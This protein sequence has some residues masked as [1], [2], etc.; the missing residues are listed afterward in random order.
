[1]VSLLMTHYTLFFVPFICFYIFLRS[2]FGRAGFRVGLRNAILWIVPYVVFSL[3]VVFSS[4]VRPSFYAERG[5]RAKPVSF[6]GFVLSEKDIF[7]E[8]F[9]QLSVMTVPNRVVDQFV[10][11]GKTKL[12][13]IK[14]LWWVSIG[15]ELLALLFLMVRRNRFLSVAMACLFSVIVLLVLN[16][17]LDRVDVYKEYPLG[18]YYF[19]PWM[20]WS[21]FLGVLVE[22]LFSIGNRL[23]DV[24]A[25]GVILLLLVNNVGE[26][27]KYQDK[28]FFR[29]KGTFAIID[30]VKEN[31]GQIESGTL[32]AVPYPLGPVGVPFL[33]MYYHR[34]GVGYIY[35]DDE[36][37]DRLRSGGVE[38]FD[39][40]L[41]LS[42]REE[43]KKKLEGEPF[44]VLVKDLFSP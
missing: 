7:D 9:F 42:F 15:V 17:Y 41:I 16:V 31:V 4:P 18:R 39:K 38:G 13:V 40:V 20:M 34:D 27:W 35:L 32:V 37:F 14:S 24:F 29:H 33:D 36:M 28:D 1:L 19:L 6:V 10:G 2:V 21:I 43:Y 11:G 30:W 8:T 26:I 25:A 44:E 12:E 3:L 22:E 5:W 23:L